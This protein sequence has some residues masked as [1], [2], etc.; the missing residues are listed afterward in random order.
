M[1]A[2]AAG[3]ARLAESTPR[4]RASAPCRA[5]CGRVS[6]AEST[7]TRAGSARRSRRS[8]DVA[9]CQLARGERGTRGKEVLY[10]PT[11]SS[12]ACR[13]GFGS[14]RFSGSMNILASGSGGHRR[15]VSARSGGSGVGSEGCWARAPA[16]ASLASASTSGLDSVSATAAANSSDGAGAAASFPVH[17]SGHQLGLSLHSCNSPL[18]ILKHATE[19]L[20]RQQE[21]MSDDIETAQDVL[22]HRT[23]WAAILG[24]LAACA[25]QSS[26]GSHIDDCPCCCR[27]CGRRR[28][29]G[30]CSAPR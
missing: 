13:N 6:R 30:L 3:R 14:S 23:C 4:T 26:F 7:R 2:E 29:L 9:G 10:V 1:S 16:P 28:R 22:S 24:W 8:V 25:E 15:S 5:P 11:R 20:D 12:S 19:Q 17:D 21:P 27:L 18:W